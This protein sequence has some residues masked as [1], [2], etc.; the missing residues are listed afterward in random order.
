MRYREFITELFDTN[1]G[2]NLSNRDER[3]MVFDTRID[4]KSI[5][6]EY[7][8][9]ADNFR[10]VSVSFTVDSE[11]DVTGSGSAMRIFGAVINNM[12][13][14]ISKVTP[15][16]VVFTSLK[17]GNTDDEYTTRSNLYKRMIIRF[18]DSMGYSYNFQDQ[19]NMDR[20]VLTKKDNNN[21]QS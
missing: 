11:Y 21:E 7:H 13:Q 16:V 18:A 10:K 2:W 5:E 12:K 1:V 15:D 4:D 20:F 3:N 6:L 17:V 14:F 8:S 19:G 9:M